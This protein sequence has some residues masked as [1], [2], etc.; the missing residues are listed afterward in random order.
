MKL[1]E[2]GRYWKT[3]PE[4]KSK[5]TSI[6]EYENGEWTTN[7]NGAPLAV[8]EIRPLDPETI[9]PIH[10]MNEIPAKEL[11]EIEKGYISPIYDYLKITMSLT[12]GLRCKFTGKSSSTVNRYT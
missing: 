2:Y 4:F 10:R 3:Y 7:G 1:L 12:S 6:L 8:E 11:S 9:D 5:S